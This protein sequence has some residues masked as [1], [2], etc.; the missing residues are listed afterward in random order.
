[1]AGLQLKYFVLKP[2]GKT[3]YHE[4]SRQAILRY[5]EVIREENPELADDLFAWLLRSSVKNKTG[6][7]KE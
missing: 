7:S 4:A 5:S 1:V 6:V 3:I 2:E